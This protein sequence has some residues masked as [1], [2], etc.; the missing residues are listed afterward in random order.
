MSRWIRWGVAAVVVAALVAGSAT[1]ALADGGRRK[2]GACSIHGDW[3]LEVSH[4]DSNT[5][6]VTFRIEHTPAGKTWEIFL[7]DNGSRFFAGTRKADS[8]GEVRVRKTTADRSG[9]D[10]VKAYGFSRA[11]G[12]TCQG[13]L[14]FDG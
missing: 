7:S 13:S 9:T 10:R 1:V 11:T 5:L 6:R 4:E 3:R 12:E 14:A 2:E 8:N